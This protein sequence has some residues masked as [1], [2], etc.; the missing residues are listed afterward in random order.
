M[1]KDDTYLI[2]TSRGGVVDEDALYDALK[3]R[4]L[5]GAG[6]DVLQQEPPDPQNPLFSLENVII[7]PHMASSTHESMIRMALTVSEDV[8]KVLHKQKPQ[9]I[10]N[11]EVLQ[12]K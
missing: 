8:V 1:M 4:K 5:K 11:P 6:L 9:F 3:N 10:A 2:N 7:T 12:R